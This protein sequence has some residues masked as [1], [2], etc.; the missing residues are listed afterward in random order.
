[1]RRTGKSQNINAQLDVDWLMGK[2]PDPRLKMQA[3]RS[4][5]PQLFG[6]TVVLMSILS[7]LYIWPTAS[8]HWLRNHWSQLLARGVGD[9]ESLGLMIALQELGEQGTSTIV[10]Q[11]NEASEERQRMAFQLLR[12]QIEN[13]S[14]QPVPSAFWMKIAQSI[15]GIQDWRPEAAVLKNQLASEILQ[16]CNG[17]SSANP[18]L[19]VLCHRIISDKQNDFPSMVSTSLI[20]KLPTIVEATKPRN[21]A[22]VQTKTV[23][24]SLSSLP[25]APVPPTVQS[26]PVAA[27]AEV[28]LPSV[29]SP[30]S[31][32]AKRTRGAAS[33]T[34]F[35]LSDSDAPTPNPDEQPAVAVTASALRNPRTGNGSTRPAVAVV[36]EP[37][38]IDQNIAISGMTKQVEVRGLNTLSIEDLF[39]KL[40]STQETQVRSAFDEL[41]KRGV[42]SNLIELAM[43]L[44]RATT[45]R[46]LELLDRL[47]RIEAGNPLPLLF[48]MAQCEDRDVRQR[49]LSLIGSTQDPEAIQKLRNLVH[50]EPDQQLQNMIHQALAAN[51][52]ISR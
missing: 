41:I 46:K 21:S 8:T 9:D 51:G 45:D 36:A 50:R 2:R 12:Q 14:Q 23:K 34:S 10:S 13:A 22:P 31:T 44:T 30:S 48:W 26:N 24:V 28:P 20:E 29:P 19:E 27:T 35:R 39:S 16:R 4:R 43:E 33:A 6:L 38:S 5:I 49:S 40:G 11:L 42:S 15:D 32:E 37:T 18:D 17:L 3:R 25:A 1:M 52:I 7:A 47:L